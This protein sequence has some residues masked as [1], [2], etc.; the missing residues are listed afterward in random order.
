[1]KFVEFSNEL[2]DLVEML[3]QSRA[4]LP[5]GFDIVA[6]QNVQAL[7]LQAV[8]LPV[9]ARALL[10]EPVPFVVRIGDQLET[11]LNFLVRCR[12]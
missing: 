12:Y 1:M 2:M 8:L 9:Q 11:R 6:L 10:T 5:Q 4:I 3:P 7:G